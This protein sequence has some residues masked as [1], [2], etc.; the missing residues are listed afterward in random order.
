MNKSEQLLSA[1]KGLSEEALASGTK[2]K[3]MVGG[4]EKMGSIVSYD[5]ESDSYKVDCDGQ[6][7][8]VAASDVKLA[9]SKTTKVKAATKKVAETRVNFAKRLAALRA[10]QGKTNEEGEDELPPADGA[11]PAADPAPEMDPKALLSECYGM[12]MDSLDGMKDALMQLQAGEP[13]EACDNTMQAMG[14]LEAAG[15]KLGEA[16][17]A[18]GLSLPSKDGDADAGDGGNM[19][20][21]GVQA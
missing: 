9:E 20:D 14:D 1:V 19:M 15:Q 18:D 6:E 21:R 2:V 3:C 17:E 7:I 4:E 5:A 13:M 10:R 12:M 16:M 8:S 11:A